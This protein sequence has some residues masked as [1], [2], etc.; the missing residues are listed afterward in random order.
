MDSLAQALD[1]LEAHGEAVIDHPMTAYMALR[2]DLE[3]LVTALSQMG[4]DH[5][6]IGAVVE[7]L[8]MGADSISQQTP[9]A[10]PL[11]SL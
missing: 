10:P 8:M 1:A 3:R 11:N 4:G 9:D 7:Q 6:R 2:G 5:A